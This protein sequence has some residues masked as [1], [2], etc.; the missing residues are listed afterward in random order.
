MFTTFLTK[1]FKSR[2]AVCGMSSIEYWLELIGHITMGVLIFI[3]TET[4]AVSGFWI[5]TGRFFLAYAVLQ[6]YV[7]II[8]DPIQEYRKPFLMA[9][10]FAVLKQ[11]E[12]V[13]AAVKHFYEDVRRGG[14][15][16]TR[17]AGALLEAV[18]VYHALCR[19]T[20]LGRGF[21]AVYDELDNQSEHYG[22]HPATL[23]LTE[24]EEVPV[25]V[26]FEIRTILGDGDP[27]VFERSVVV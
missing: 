16:P 9:N 2:G 10:A 23:T 26:A 21:Y 6:A 12:A 18:I 20:R 11:Y 3:L 5:W 19:A 14:G 24:R 25:P 13:S 27:F 7:W 4:F 22:V 1:W 17:S 15:N 8:W